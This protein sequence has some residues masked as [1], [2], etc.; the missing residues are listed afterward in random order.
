MQ[1]SL[2]NQPIVSEL[3]HKNELWSSRSTVKLMNVSINGRRSQN[4]CLFTLEHLSPQEPAWVL[5]SCFWKGNFKKTKV[6]ISNQVFGCGFTL[7]P[8]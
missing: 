3:T 7:C 1:R 2:R 6:E 8:L 5:T 4:M